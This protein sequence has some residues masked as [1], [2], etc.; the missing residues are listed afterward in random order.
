MLSEL[1]LEGAKL[2]GRG[3]AAIGAA[4]A[5]GALRQMVVRQN[6]QEP[7]NFLSV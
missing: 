5:A 2:S 3:V 4:A 6:H 7:P 1:F